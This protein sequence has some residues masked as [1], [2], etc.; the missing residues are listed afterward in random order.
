MIRIV[1]EGLQRERSITD[2]AFLLL[3]A[4][5]LLSAGY[6]HTSGYSVPASFACVLLIVGDSYPLKCHSWHQRVQG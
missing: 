4:P 5:Q 3:S 2:L 6:V 1:I